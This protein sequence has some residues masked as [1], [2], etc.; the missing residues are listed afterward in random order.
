[1]LNANCMVTDQSVNW[2]D[3][4]TGMH[5][6]L[7]RPLKTV[8]LNERGLLLLGVHGFDFYK[9]QSVNRDW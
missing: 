7:V 8:A 6:F 5:N 9:T 4:L 3:T 2:T 1:M